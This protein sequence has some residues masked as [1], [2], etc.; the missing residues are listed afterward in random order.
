MSIVKDEG[1]YDIIKTLD[2]EP[3]LKE[4]DRYLINISS[5]KE[6]NHSSGLESGQPKIFVIKSEKEFSYVGYASESM[7]PR[8]TKGLAASL[9]KAYMKDRELETKELDLYIFEFMLFA[10]F[11]KTETRQYYQSIQS[12][13]IYLIKAE[14]G[15]WP[16][17]QKQINLWN[18]NQEEAKE[19]A[20]EMILI[21]KS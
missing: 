12:E 7:F 21:L 20:Y 8:I 5:S 3:F 6:E 16:I 11:S 2:L 15:T 14:T 19:I 9:A 18:E 17:L 10:D 1:Q 13:L 4:E